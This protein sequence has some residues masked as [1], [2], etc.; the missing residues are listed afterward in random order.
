MRGYVVRNENNT[1]FAPH[2][3]Q[4]L[5]LKGRVILPHIK[6]DYDGLD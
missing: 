4:S 6:I 3:P 1:N 2:L 5:I